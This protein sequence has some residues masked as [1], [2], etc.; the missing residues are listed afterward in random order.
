M[1]SRLAVLDASPLIAFHQ[2]GRLD[3][4]R[5]VYDTVIV[6]PAVS[7]EIAPS[8]GTLPSWVQVTRPALI[9]TMLLDLDPGEQEAIALAVQLD[10][11][12]IVLDDLAARRAATRMGLTLTGSAGLLVRAQRLGLLEVVR[13]D[14]DAMIANGLFIS[15]S[16]YR[17]VLQSLG[18]LSP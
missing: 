1:T 2:I 13:P 3:L 6:P 16:L 17:D 5:H 11:D 10:A 15:E 8:L 18:E 9:P 12:V 4:V 7:H 14:L